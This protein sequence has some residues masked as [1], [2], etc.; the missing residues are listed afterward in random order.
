MPV[1]MLYEVQSSSLLRNFADSY[2][3]VNSPNEWLKKK[4]VRIVRVC[5]DLLIWYFPK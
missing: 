2:L 3:R 5:Q 4:A 1:A